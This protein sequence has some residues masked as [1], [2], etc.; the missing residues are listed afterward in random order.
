MAPVAKGAPH[1]CVDT[2]A[3]PAQDDSSHFLE[4]SEGIVDGSMDDNEFPEGGSGP[5]SASLCSS[6]RTSSNASF[7][8]S[9]FSSDSLSERE[10]LHFNPDQYL[11]MHKKA[12]AERAKYGH[13]GPRMKLLYRYWC[14]FLLYNF[15]DAMYRSFLV[16]A[17]EDAAQG[18]LH[19]LRLLF[20]FFKKRLASCFDAEQFCEFEQLAHRYHDYMDYEYGIRCL[21]ELLTMGTSEVVTA[22]GCTLSAMTVSLLEAW[23]RYVESCSNQSNLAPE[24]GSDEAR[25]KLHKQLAEKRKKRSKA[26]TRGIQGQAGAGGDEATAGFARGHIAGAVG[27]EDAGGQ[28]LGGTAWEGCQE[29]VVATGGL[30]GGKEQGQGQ[31]QVEAVGEAE[32][33]SEEVQERRKERRPGVGRGVVCRSEGRGAKSLGGYIQQQLLQQQQQQQQRIPLMA[34]QKKMLRAKALPWMPQAQPRSS[35]HPEAQRLPDRLGERLG[36]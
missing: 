14:E 30:K 21:L 26:G 20:S 19:G 6:P 18:S 32:G 10:V 12:L 2:S 17:Q 33:R 35:S 4:P 24:T 3:L 29:E 13:S 36:N 5:S 22:S 16:L 15:N 25:V 9:S 31:G 7:C 27:E 1:I 23:G 28:Q 34:M 8:S 11:M